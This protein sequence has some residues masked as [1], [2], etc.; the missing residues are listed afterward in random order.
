M[1]NT[2]ILVFDPDE[3]ERTRLAK[4]L[5]S[6]GHDAFGTD[7]A[8]GM[9]EAVQSADI[10]VVFL[11][12]GESIGHFTT[13]IGAIRGA[14]PHTAVVLTGSSRDF[15]LLLAV[16]RTGADDYIVKPFQEAEVGRRLAA[17]L[18]RR[19][20]A[21]AE[22]RAE[23]ENLLKAQQQVAQEYNEV[24]ISFHEFQSRSLTA[25]LDLQRRNVSLERQIRNLENPGFDASQRSQVKVLIAHADPSVSERF[26]KLVDTINIRLERQ[27]FTGGELLDRIGAEPADLL[28]IGSDLPDIPGE[29]VA[30]SAKAENPNTDVVLLREQA[31]E[32]TLELISN[33][34]GIETTRSLSSFGDLVTFLGEQC[35]TLS[36]RD[37]ARQFAQNFKEQHQEYISALIDMK[38]RIEKVLKK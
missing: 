14:S 18:A 23:R 8:A 27:A 35:L 12:V 31:G 13:L 17:V 2:P 24:L 22:R 1:P 20:L 38:K 7:T 16:Y 21:A 28:L 36:K 29:I 26:E 10:P 30:S 33:D 6:Y 25:F 9:V 11:D 32:Y 4:I 5:T 3:Q 19:R 34:S 15:D 37:E